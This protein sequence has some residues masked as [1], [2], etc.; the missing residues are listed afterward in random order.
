MNTELNLEDISLDYE[1]N[2]A[3]IED[4]YSIKYDNI[5]NTGSYSDKFKER[6]YNRILEEKN[7]SLRQNS[8]RKTEQNLKLE[9]KLGRNDDGSSIHDWMLSSKDQDVKVTDQ[10]FT[11]DSS[12]L[13]KTLQEA[14]PDYEFRTSYET[15]NPFLNSLGLKTAAADAFDYYKDKE[16]GVIM[17][18]PNTGDAIRLHSGRNAFD[19]KD[20][21]CRTKSSIC[22]SS[23]K[24]G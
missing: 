2:I 21:W 12:E 23:T 22:R 18:D 11:G 17:T 9:S 13:T 6:E 8:V 20:V 1:K 19:R 7:E 4:D 5:T 15:V 24:K 10:A 14:Y 16:V 3:D